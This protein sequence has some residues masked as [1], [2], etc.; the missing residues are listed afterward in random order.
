MA[1]DFYSNLFSF[2]PNANI[3]A[4]LDAIPTKVDQNIIEELYKPY[5]DEEI[6][7]ALFQ[8]GPTKA[9]GPDGFLAL[10]YQ[11]HWDLLHKE[12]CQ[13][14]K[15]FLSE[16]EIPEGLCNTTIVL[17]P[18]VPRP[19]HLNN[20]RPISLCNVIYKIASKVLSNRLKLFLPNIFF[21]EHT[22]RRQRSKTPFFALKIDMMKAY[23]RVEWAY[24]RGVLQKLGF[25]DSWIS[26]VMWCVSSVHYAI[27]I[28]GELT[29]TFYPTRGIR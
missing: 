14:V 27:R 12:I 24:L 17:I 7:K 21:Q 15:S 23:D 9:P 3:E 10:F 6:K 19:E 5:T 25:H 29:Q 8:M 26:I 28:N 18:K 20:F 4:I 11:R 2:E 13:A 16:D 1:K 22:I